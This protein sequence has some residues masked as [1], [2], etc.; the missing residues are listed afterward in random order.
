MGLALPDSSDDD[1]CSSS[2]TT[3][4]YSGSEDDIPY[5]TDATVDSNLDSNI[6]NKESGYSAKAK[7]CAWLLADNKHSSEYYIQ[8]IKHINESEYAKQNY[9]I[10]LIILFNSIKK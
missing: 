2:D 3:Q 4:H 6:N 1:A 9:S 8:Q 5:E 7:N 10:S